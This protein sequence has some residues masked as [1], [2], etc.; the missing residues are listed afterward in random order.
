[1]NARARAS[2]RGAPRALARATK[3]RYAGTF[4]ARACDDDDVMGEITERN[5]RWTERECARVMDD[6]YARRVEANANGNANANARTGTGTGATTTG[7]DAFAKN[8]EGYYD[9]RYGARRVVDVRA[10]ELVI[11]AECARL[12]RASEACETFCALLRGTI[13]DECAEFFL[14]A[15]ER[16]A[17]AC[18]DMCRRGEV[19]RRKRIG[20]EEKKGN[21]SAERAGRVDL[22]DVSL[23]EKQA[24]A[25]VR[26]VF[27]GA[28]GEEERF[29]SSASTS[30]AFLHATV[31]AMVGAAF[32]DARWAT[33]KDVADGPGKGTENEGSRGNSVPCEGV[34]M[35]AYRL[36]RMLL[37]VFVDTTPPANAEA[38]ALATT[39][40]PATRGLE[41]AMNAVALDSAEGTK[42]PQ[43]VAPLVMDWSAEIARFELAL[44]AALADAT[45][46][47][48]AAVFPAKVPR[49]IIAEAEVKL[50]AVAQEMLTSVIDNAADAS[51][52]GE[53]VTE[54]PVACKAYARARDSILTGAGTPGSESPSMGSS[55]RDVAR[56]ILATPKIRQTIEP[57]LKSAL[58][59]LK[60]PPN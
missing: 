14:Y 38:P 47:Y 29:S 36:L 9:R 22:S 46:K 11:N 59:L 33:K 53:I 13:D 58:E 8:V 34:R 50:N 51:S 21:V 55:T 18:D 43:S 52:A 26:A 32:D 20:E 45:N 48:C 40:T 10:M 49:A 6:A 39:A 3:E 30:S 54:A 25:C 44:R 15:R 16:C 24:L 35:D 37:S 28:E 27:L 17:R 7:R 60:S 5:V 2:H 1:M 31:R 56:A 19:L 4:I 23:D 12:T 57:V 42:T 41:A